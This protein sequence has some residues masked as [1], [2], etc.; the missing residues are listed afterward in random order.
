MINYQHVFLLVKKNN[1]L[2]NCNVKQTLVTRK[3]VFGSVVPFIF[4]SNILNV[5]LITHFCF[6]LGIMCSCIVE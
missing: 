3:L 5:V 1:A 6:F 4:C 2:E